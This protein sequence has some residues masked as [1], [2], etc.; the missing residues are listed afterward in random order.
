MPMY[1]TTEFGQE[2]AQYHLA[3]ALLDRGAGRDRRE[4]ARLLEQAAE[5]GDYS[6]ATEL[7]RQLNG[8]A[9]CGCIAAVEGWLAGSVG[10]IIVS[11]I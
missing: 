11:Y 2:E 4:A 8:V 10:K 9:H 6:Q 5:D 1:Y 3:I 7:L